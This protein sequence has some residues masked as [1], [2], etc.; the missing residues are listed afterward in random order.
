M[1]HNSIYYKRQFFLSLFLMVLYFII[2]LPLLFIP[3]KDFDRTLS[4]VSIFI[5]FNIPFTMMFIYYFI[6]FSYAKKINLKDIQK[7]KLEKTYPG[8]RGYSGF[9]VKMNINGV[10]KK[11]ETIII[12]V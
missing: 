6:K 11:V 10:I 1:N 8:F 2:L 9:I 4:I 7:I 5:I 3:N 12:L